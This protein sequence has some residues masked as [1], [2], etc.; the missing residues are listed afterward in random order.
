MIKKNIFD[1]SL[2]LGSKV[3]LE[4]FGQLSRFNNAKLS[5]SVI[6]NACAGKMPHF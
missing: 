2:A 3:R 4:K 1:V 6:K 5:Y